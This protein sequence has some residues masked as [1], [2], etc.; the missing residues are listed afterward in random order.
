MMSELKLEVGKRYETD[1]PEPR[2]VFIHRRV[3][4]LFFG[5]MTRTANASDIAWYSDGSKASAD[6]WQPDIIRCLDDEP[7]LVDLTKIDAPFGELD[8]RTQDR[9]VSASARGA[10][11]QAPNGTGWSTVTTTAWYG[12]VRYRVKPTEPTY[13]MPTVDAKV[14]QAMPRA[15]AIAWDKGDLDGWAYSTVPLRGEFCTEWSQDD[16]TYARLNAALFG[17]L[18]QRGDCPW[19]QAIVLRPEG[20]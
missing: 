18:I 20:L 17:D 11:I 7:E 2:V 16:G 15:K 10:Q 1:E 12:S 3:G 19:D 14:W 5:A 13:V 8:K 9:L 4:A 6:E